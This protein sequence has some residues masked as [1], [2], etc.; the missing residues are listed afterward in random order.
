MAPPKSRT[1]DPVSANALAM[2]E[3][4]WHLQDGEYAKTELAELTGVSIHT[5]IRWFKLLTRP[6]KRLVY[7]CEWRRRFK[8]GAWQQIWTWGPGMKD[9]PKPIKKYGPEYW[10]EIRMARKMDKL[11]TLGAE[12]GQ[13]RV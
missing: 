13:S 10:R 9:V 7:I 3:L 1:A 11:R 2:V 8:A 4:I 5:I 12:S 6:N